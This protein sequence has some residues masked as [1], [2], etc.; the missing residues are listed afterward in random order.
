MI[1]EYVLITASEYE[2]L[3]ND[4]DELSELNATGVDNWSG[5]GECDWEELEANELQI[6][7]VVKNMKKYTKEGAL[8]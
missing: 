3:L 4:S 2:S 5:Y 8:V 7:Q 6:E 1:K